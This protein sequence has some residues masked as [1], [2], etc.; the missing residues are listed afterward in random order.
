MYKNNKILV[1]IPARGGSKGIPRKNIRLLGGKP[2]IA[3]T[4]EITKASEYVDELVVTTDDNEIAFVA[5]KFGAKTIKRDGKL[6]EDSI[7]L[8]PVIYDATIKQEEKEGEKYDVV[9][10]VVVDDRHLSWGWDEENKKYYPLYKARLN[11]Q[12][13]P[14]SYKE[15]GSIFASKRKFICENS[16][17]GDNIGL[18]EV[19]KQE[20]IDID[21]YEDWWVA[22]R[23]LKKKK[24]LIKTDAS[25]DIGTGHV[26]RSLSIAS[27][28]INHEVIFL[29]D[30]A[31][32]LGIEIVKNN[33]YP[34]ITHNTHQAESEEAN[35]EAKDEVVEKIEAYGPDIV[36]NDILNTKSKYTKALRDRGY[37][38]VNFEDLGG[39][40]KYA[41]LIFD[42]LYE[43]KI[44]LQ[45]LYS[46]HNFYILKDEFY[47]QSPKEITE[48]V[49]RILLTFGGSDPNNFTEKVTESILK[50]SY[51]NEIEIILGLGY[52]N[53]KE[54]QEKY[55][56][57]D[58]ITIYENV[59][60]MSEHMHSA[61]LIFTSAGRTMYEIASLG[62]PCVCLCQ[63]ER[64][65]SH[66]F[67]NVENGFIN[68]GLGVNITEEQILETLESLL[69]NYELRCEMSRRMK[70]IDLK[71]GFENIA[72][73]I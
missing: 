4:I 56:D 42:A 15:T 17:L 43:H 68:L 55:K 2:L 19:S 12:Y 8:D 38:I 49:N 27:K 58:R 6:A 24:I 62:V 64:E 33:N 72:E 25:H 20:S 32:P 51:E 50:S 16:R 34:Y 59:K 1:V 13:L 36:I 47:Y 60:N 48:D 11:R 73:R 5:G 61:D 45:N 29:L 53:K 44:P 67:G 66:I 39:G 46:G 63:N 31:K 54:I 23:I 18:I 26:Y 30:E 35:Q 21:N 57:N 70:S 40:I 3:H 10:T 22:E 9:I 14:K 37:F 69:D 28:L 41:H 65:L 52:S 71:H 7:P